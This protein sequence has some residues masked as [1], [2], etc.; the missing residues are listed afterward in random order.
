MKNPYIYARLKEP[1][2]WRGIVMLLTG[3]GVNLSPET[4]S[5]IVSVGVGLVG[6]IGVASKD[7]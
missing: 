7:K 3:L 6:L 2:T 1:S 5:Q 4:A